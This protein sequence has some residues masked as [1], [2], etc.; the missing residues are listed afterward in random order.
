[1]DNVPSSN[2]RKTKMICRDGSGLAS[3]DVEAFDERG[4]EIMKVKYLYKVMGYNFGT[5]YGRRWLND[6]TADADGRAK[7]DLLEVLKHRVDHFKGLIDLFTDFRTGQDNL[8]TNEDQEDDLGLD[9][10]IDETREQLR[11]VG[12]EVVMA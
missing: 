5:S 11:F 2:Y 7:S 10:S 1:M 9:H 8:A 3:L 6:R 12:A 4:R